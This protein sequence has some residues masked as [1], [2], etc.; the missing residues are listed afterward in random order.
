VDLELRDPARLIA[1]LSIAI[2]E[3]LAQLLVFELEVDGRHASDN[4][5]L[6]AAFHE[7]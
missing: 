4:A 3:L 1:D 5:D 6:R 2:S 7:D